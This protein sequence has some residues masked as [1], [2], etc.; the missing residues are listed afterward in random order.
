MCNTIEVICNVIANHTAIT[1]ILQRMLHNFDFSNYSRVTGMV[2]AGNYWSKKFLDQVLH[3][4]S[5]IGTWPGVLSDNE[6]PNL[7][8]MNL[9][10]D[11]ENLR[12]KDKSFTR[13]AFF[14]WRFHC[15]LVYAVAS[16]EQTGSHGV[17]VGGLLCRGEQVGQWGGYR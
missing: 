8:A 6:R 4:I 12:K 9:P 10:P 14:I 13:K 11:D 1:G 15:I 17:L 5:Y 2:V 7:E 3:S 16:P